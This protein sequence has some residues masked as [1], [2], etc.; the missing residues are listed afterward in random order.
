[1][2]ANGAVVDSGA[3]DAARRA[4]PRRRRS[5]PPASPS[6]AARCSPTTPWRRASAAKYR[7]KNT[8]GYSLNALLD[9]AEPH[10]ILDHL[11]IGSE[12][13]LA[14]IA[15]AVLRTLPS[16]PHRA[17]GVLYFPGVHAAA[18]AIEPLRGS[19]A[20]ALELMDGASLAAVAGH[21][22]APAELAEV[23]AARAGG[24]GAAG[25]VPPRPARR[26]RRRA[27]RGRTRAFAGLDLLA[28]PG[29]TEDPLRQARLWTIRKG[30]YPSVGAVRR[31]GTAVIIEDVAFPVPRLADA[32]I[33]LQAL[34]AGHG[35]DEAIVFGHAKD[36]NLHFVLTPDFDVPAEV[37]R[38]ERFMGGLADLVVRRFDGSLKAE[39]GTGRNMAPFVEAEWGGAAYAADAASSRRCSTRDGLL[40]PGVLLDDDPRAHLARP[41]AAARGRGGGRPLHR[42]RLLRATLPEP[43]ADHH[44]APA[45]R[46]P[47]GNG[48]ARIAGAARCACRARQRFPAYDV[49]ATCAADGLCATV[50]PVAINTGDSR[51]AAPGRAASA[52]V[53]Q[54]GRSGSLVISACW[55]PCWPRASSW[56]T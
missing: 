10:R 26:S 21:P 15:E 30:L 16:Y 42:V 51:Q 41:Q 23:T 19:G 48:P 29:L 3:A 22:G 33:E 12:G 47:P 14:F 45:H 2:L 44:A 18:A 37:A 20:R 34:F 52:R 53:Q 56:D 39:H 35:Y 6:C 43:A 27:P 4:G 8:V 17:T 7:L 54:P 50:C 1:M 25:R 13:T 9:H 40:A 31:R 5:S 28:A 24:R 55:R 46:A 11:L 32:V 36:G 38:Y 49:E